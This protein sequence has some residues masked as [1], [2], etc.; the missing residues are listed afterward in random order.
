MKWK[1]QGT[2]YH[3][4]QPLRSVRKKTLSKILRHYFPGE[5]FFLPREDKIYYLPSSTGILKNTLYS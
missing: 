5:S 1:L 4:D 2:L 3:P